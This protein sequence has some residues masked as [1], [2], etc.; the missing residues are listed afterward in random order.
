[1]SHL[2]QTTEDLVMTVSTKRFFAI[3]ISVQV[4]APSVEYILTKYI[5]Q[6]YPNLPDCVSISIDELEDPSDESE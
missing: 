6:E 3:K 5:P 1:M 4:M 2:Q